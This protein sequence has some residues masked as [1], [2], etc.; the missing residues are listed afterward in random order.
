MPLNY[1]STFLEYSAASLL[2]AG[3][4]CHTVSKQWASMS[5]RPTVAGLR[6]KGLA[7]RCRPSS[8][9][10]RRSPGGPPP[11]GRRRSPRV[12]ARPRGGRG[13]RR[14]PSCSGARCCLGESPPVRAETSPAGF[15][16]AT[17]L[18]ASAINGAPSPWRVPAGPGGDII[19]R[20]PPGR[21]GAMLARLRPPRAPALE[22]LRTLG[23]NR[24]FG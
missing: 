8:P 12:S 2:F 6:P 15:R 19:C 17:G 22:Y 3:Q 18:G 13:S 10:A 24:L 7:P 21:A 14:W 1:Y 4:S 11:D 5:G 20:S 23:Q 16:P 9:T